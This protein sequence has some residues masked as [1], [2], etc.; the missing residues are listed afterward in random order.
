M[1]NQ[2]LEENENNNQKKEKPLW[3]SLLV[4]NLI[5]IVATIFLGYLT[6]D[7]RSSSRSITPAIITLYLGF[8]GIEALFFII[9]SLFVLFIAK[10]KNK[11][12][13]LFLFGVILL[14]VVFLIYGVLSFPSAPPM[15]V[16]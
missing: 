2:N 11:A 4:I 15:M 8:L 13:K 14:L 9:F 5:I 12:K 16:E 10:N 7:N 6:S 1:E 3:V